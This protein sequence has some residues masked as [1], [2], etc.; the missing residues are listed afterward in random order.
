M[1]VSEI[2]KFLVPLV[3]LQIGF[4]VYA[5]YDLVAKKQRKTRNLNFAIWL[6]III[7]GEIAG[8]ALY[9][10]LVRSEE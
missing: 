10:I 1:E 3:V 2:I 4:Q 7:L 5:I 9:F 6:V 8:P